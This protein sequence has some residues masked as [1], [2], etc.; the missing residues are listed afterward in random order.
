MTSNDE[1]GLLLRHLDAQ[2]RHVL[3]AI[4]G[5]ADEELRRPKQANE[6]VGDR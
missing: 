4:D 3:S 6:R 2:R 1:R 5:L